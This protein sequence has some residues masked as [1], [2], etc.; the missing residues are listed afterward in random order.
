LKPGDVILALDNQAVDDPDSFGFRYAIKV[1]GETAQLK[2]NRNGKVMNVAVKTVMAPETRPRDLV[3]LSGHWPLSG[4]T[5]GNFSPALAEDFGLPTGGDGVVVTEVKSGS[6]ADDLGI[7]KGDVIVSIDG[8][9]VKATSDAVALQKSR[10]Y[11]WPLVVK[12]DGQV[13]TTQV[14]G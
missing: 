7:K 12:R 4:V 1:I 10:Q 8:V 14:G 11:Y 2:I 6:P 9:A 5:L 3:T 13:L